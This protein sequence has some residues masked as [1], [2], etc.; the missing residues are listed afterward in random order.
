MKKDP[1]NIE[2]TRR[3][4]VAFFSIFWIVGL[5]PL[6][7]ISLLILFQSED[8]LPPVSM[9]DNPPELQASLIIARNGE[10]GDTVIGQFWKVNRTSIKY[11]DISPHVLDALIS[12]E[13]E[14]F[15]KHSGVD[16]RALM[17][18]VSGLGS[19]G[20][21]STITQQLAKQ[22]YTLNERKDNNKGLS[23]A[24]KFINVKARENII[25]KRLEERFTK[26][27]ILTFYLNQVDFLYNAV[28]LKS[29]AKIYFNK[30]PKDLSKLEAATLVGMCKNPGL[31][32]PFGYKVKDY[33]SKIAHDKGIKITSVTKEDIAQRRMEDS[34]RCVDRRN[35]VLF[36]WLKNS[37]SQNEALKSYLTQT[38][39]DSLKLMPIQVDYTPL[40]HKEGL[41]PYFR[42]SLR[43]EV[44]TILNA[45]DE[46]GNLKIKREDGKAYNVYTDG[47]KIYTT[48][49]P[50]LQRHA[51]YALRRHLGETLQNEFDKNNK[52]SVYF[53][54]AKG[55]KEITAKNIINR[56]KKN[57]KRFKDLQKSGYS[58]EEI[59]ENFDTPT[60][61]RIFSWKGEIDTMM[62][63]LDS[64]KYYKSFLHAGLVS[65]DPKTGFVQAWVGGTDLKH[66]AYDHV[67][68]GKR[69]VGSTI[70]PF[71]YASAL[72]MRVVTPC[73]EFTEEDYCIETIGPNNEPYGK[74]FCPRGKA[75]KNVRNGLAGSSN[76]TT[77]AVLKKMGPFKPS[78]RTGGPFIV[79][80]LL[81]SM[82]IQLR[83]EDVVPAMCLGVMDLTLLELT[84]A[85]CV[86]PN[87]GIFIRPTAIERITDRNGKI[88]YSAD[89]HMEQALNSSVA[90]ET[91]KLMKGVIQG[92]T[93]TSLR[94][95]QPWGGITNPTAG[96]T[97]TTQNNSDGWFIGITPDLVTGV[98]V[99]A[100]DKQVRFRSMLWGQGA[101]MALPIYGYY[102][103]KVYK[104][105][106]IKLFSGDF[107]PPSDYNERAFDCN[108]EAI[109]DFEN[110]ENLISF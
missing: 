4:K 71:V 7:F 63:P 5:F 47:L 13:D 37:K 70:K 110:L 50:Y 68:Q 82:D 49:N 67:G 14:R 54:F 58:I 60:S 88:I 80:K 66:F 6:V 45:V 78:A 65:I 19:S 51:E 36:Q 84:A 39:Y 101:R 26:E 102:M 91:L 53:P 77:T 44:T 33:R 22:F 17:R 97:G 2:L 85:Q 79:E 32:N 38:E 56:A 42:E 105:K 46:N 86:F 34:M 83:P 29:A 15:Y 43:K 18:A 25:A 10:K 16:L 99:G 75:A 100:E 90:Y 106:N 109:E 57:T 81:N 72:G 24:F 11:R 87:N 95:S 27:E 74:P 23:K 12:T 31:F 28:G 40:D 55:T 98:W 35:Q 61:M 20:G 21:A 104:D 94:S 1:K 52:S 73:T 108:N 8:N 103:Q 76:P 30:E 9:L 62:S 3:D 93:G 69:Q 59:D 96:K 89:V 41:A 48:L 64:I 92:G 107:E